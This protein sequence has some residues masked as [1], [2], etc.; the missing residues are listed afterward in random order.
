MNPNEVAKTQDDPAS[1]SAMWGVLAVWL[2]SVFFLGS[3]GGFVRPAG[4]WP[5]PIVIGAVAPVVIFLLTFWTSRGFHDFILSIDRSLITAIQAWRFAGLGFVA[6]YIHGVLPGI[7]AWPAGLGDIAMGLTAPWLA[8]RL[9]RE[10]K[11]VSSG[12]FVVWNWL[13]I[14]DL[15]IAVGMGGLS[16]ALASGTPGEI[17]TAPMA[18]L[19]L[20]LIPAYFVPL[21]VML[22]LSAL[23]QARRQAVSEHLENRSDHVWAATASRG[24]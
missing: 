12:S 10:P 17:T 3:A 4:S 23:F 24:A 22:H 6:L 19:P 9:T 16:S 14:L 11:L 7:F 5:Y 2:A 8:L 18:R 20:V 13:G 21:F 1:T 15:V